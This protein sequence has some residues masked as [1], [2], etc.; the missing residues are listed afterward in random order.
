MLIMFCPS[1]RELFFLIEQNSTKLDNSA[2]IH[3]IRGGA[4]GHVVRPAS[5]LPS[6]IRQAV[7]DR[8]YNVSIDSSMYSSEVLDPPL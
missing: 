5:C 8:D 3:V 2:T 1:D 4:R 7:V 6:V